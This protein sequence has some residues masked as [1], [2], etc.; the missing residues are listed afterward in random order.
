MLLAVTDAAFEPGDFWL[1][2]TLTI[3]VV[4]VTKP[5]L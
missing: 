3:L 1:S 4:L 2:G 5:G